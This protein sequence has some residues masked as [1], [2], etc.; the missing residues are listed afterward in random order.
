M[1]KD[2]RNK[3]EAIG[4]KGMFVVYCENYKAYRIYIPSHRKVEIS[5]DVT[6]DEDATLGKEKYLCPPPPP[7]AENDDWDIMDGLSIPEYDMVDDPIEP[8][9]PLDP[10][11]SAPP[12][13]K[14]PLWLRDNL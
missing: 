13:T 14:I 11:P 9:D 2:K 12:S 6:F 8:M 7:K 5:R 1:P 3:L 10:P 4:R